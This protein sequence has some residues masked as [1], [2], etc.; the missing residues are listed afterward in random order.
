MQ[1]RWKDGSK[2]M[3]TVNALFAGFSAVLLINLT[4][5]ERQ[6]AVPDVAIWMA[7]IALFCFA[8]AAERKERSGHPLAASGKEATASQGARGRAGLSFFSASRSLMPTHPGFR[9]SG[10]GLV[11]QAAPVTHQDQGVGS[12]WQ[13]A[14]LAD[15]SAPENASVPDDAPQ[16][17]HD[18]TR[19]LSKVRGTLL[20]QPH[21]AAHR[22]ILHRKCVALAA[23]SLQSDSMV[24]PTL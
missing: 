20:L 16:E 7:V 6:G 24:W 21:L 9:F 11:L 17:G 10:I 8:F 3:L 2:G 14:P 12:A 1:P 5:R 23:R 13:S 15:S 4:T 19:G 22:G 18:R